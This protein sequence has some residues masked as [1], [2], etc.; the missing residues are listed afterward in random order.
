M[1]KLWIVVSILLAVG[2]IYVI[3]NLVKSSIHK[4]VESRSPKAGT[5]QG[6]SPAAQTNTDD[7]VESPAAYDKR[8]KDTLAEV[9]KEG[10]ASNVAI[11]FYGKVIDQDQ[12]GIPG[13]RVTLEAISFAPV[14]DPV[15]KIFV[16]DDQKKTPLELITDAG[17]RFSVTGIKGQ[18]LNVKNLQR[19]GYLS[20]SQPGNFAFSSVDDVYI[21]HPD[22][23]KPVIFRLWKKGPT[24]PLIS[25]ARSY[26]VIADGRTYSIDLLKNKIS[27]AASSSGDLRVAMKRPPQT[28]PSVP[29]EWTFTIDAVDGGIIETTDDYLYRAPDSGYQPG[30]EYVTQIDEPMK[31]HNNLK[32]KFYLKSRGGKIYASL[33]VEAVNFYTDQKASVSLEFLVNPAGSRNLE[34]SLDKKI[35]SQ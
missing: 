19:D 18:F 7:R 11:T 10:L 2:L 9:L 35:N 16:G 34:Y 15:S 22:L 17:G 25:R 6:G 1:K 14:L 21:H 3:S 20:L 28:N 27:D 24:E 30:Y 31:W 4:P 33:E 13:V 29:Y 12:V 32:K 8:V 23:Q 26:P 5:P